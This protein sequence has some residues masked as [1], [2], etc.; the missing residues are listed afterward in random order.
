[1][2]RFTLPSLAWL[3]LVHSPARGAGLTP[4]DA[5]FLLETDSPHSSKAI[6]ALAEKGGGLGVS[7]LL[8]VLDRLSVEERRIVAESFRGPHSEQERVFDALFRLAQDEAPPVR[9]AALDSLRRSRSTGAGLTLLRLIDAEYSD[10]EAVAK[11]IHRFAYAHLEETAPDIRDFQERGV[12]SLSPLLTDTSASV[13]RETVEALSCFSHPRA[14]DLLFSRF[15]DPDANTRY[16][17]RRR[18]FPVARLLPALLHYARSLP[19]GDERRESF[20]D[21]GYWH[22]RRELPRFVEMFRSA[23]SPQEKDD[24]RSLLDRCGY[25]FE[26]EAR[27]ALETYRNDPDREIRERAVT[28]LGWV[29]EAER[30]ASKPSTS[31]IFLLLTS[32]L[33]AVLGLLL[34]FWAFRLLKLRALLEGLGLANAESI[35]LGT[36]AISGEAQPRGDYLKHPYTG[37]LCVWYRGAPPEHRFY[38]EDGTGRVLVDPQDA[39]LLSEDGLLSPGERIHVVATARRNPDTSSTS[40]PSER[41]VLRKNEEARPFHRRIVNLLVGGLLGVTAGNRSMRCLFDDPHSVFWIWDDVRRR[42]MSSPREVILIFIV[43]LFAGGWMVVFFLS[44]TAA[45]GFDL[46]R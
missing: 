40:N 17:A 39:V 3:L 14:E 45:M 18:V 43:A 22:C 44:T 21:I 2:S 34:F 46:L 20:S 26:P 1:M 10:R 13:R 4:E 23:G 15:D 36:V 42:P 25:E 5:S 8:R 16:L 7:S 32:A 35:A 41:I 19:A 24:Y 12:E 38:L 11:A 27:A 31:L 33:S 6:R 9:E 30:K 28:L 29:A 37:E